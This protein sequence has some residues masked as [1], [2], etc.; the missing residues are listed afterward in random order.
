[1]RIRL[2]AA[3]AVVAAT[4]MATFAGAD[5]AGWIED[6]V[7]QWQPTER[8]KRWEA[9]GWA[10]SIGEALRLAREHRRPVFLFTLDGRM[11]VGRC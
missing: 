5:E 3:A 10:G 2:M 8:E 11:G 6:R 9:I 4:A 7:R 1:M